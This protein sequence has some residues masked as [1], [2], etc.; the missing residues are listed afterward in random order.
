M[1]WVFAAIRDVAKESPIE[2]GL[3][4]SSSLLI[5]GQEAKVGLA[6][7]LD[8]EGRRQAYLGNRRCQNEVGGV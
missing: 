2:S 5:E 3:E 7:G 1:L 6:A 8:M 4:T